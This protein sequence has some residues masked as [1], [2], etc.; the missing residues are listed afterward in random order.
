MVQQATLHGS[1]CC[2]AVGD[3]TGDRFEK[4]G[5]KVRALKLANMTSRVLRWA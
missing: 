3:E 2:T 4:I 1:V 5:S